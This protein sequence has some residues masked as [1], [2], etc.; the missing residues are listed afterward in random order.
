MKKVVRWDA[1]KITSGINPGGKAR[2]FF[3][4]EFQKAV[5]R[6]REQQSA[7][8]YLR[9]ANPVMVSLLEYKLKNREPLIVMRTLQYQTSELQKNEDDDGFYKV[10]NQSHN[11]KYVDVL[12]TILPG[13][14]LV[15]KSLD[16]SL[17][18]FIFEDGRGKEH[19][20]NFADRDRLMTQTNVFE[21]VRAFLSNEEN[22]R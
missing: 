1:P 17:Q 8:E 21:E 11:E 15:L 16:M 7:V 10:K 20:I 9:K 2:K 4:E 13:T 12:R 6:D 5:E 19:A 14:K 18:E 3:K 22:I